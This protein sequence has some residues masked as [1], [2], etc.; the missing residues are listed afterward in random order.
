MLIIC[1]KPKNYEIEHK[2]PITSTLAAR[3]PATLTVADETASAATAAA[4]PTHANTTTGQAILTLNMQA[5]PIPPHPCAKP[6]FLHAI[7]HF[8]IFCLT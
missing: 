6:I 5:P 7:P 4:P 8:L 1:Q 3:T 2:D